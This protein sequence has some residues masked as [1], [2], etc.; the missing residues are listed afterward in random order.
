LSPKPSRGC[1]NVDISAAPRFDVMKIIA[2]VKSTFRLSPSVRV[3]LSRMPSSRFQSESDAFS[4][5]SKR[6]K[7]IL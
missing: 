7:L 1:S 2:L 5:S 3:A 4:I 6:M